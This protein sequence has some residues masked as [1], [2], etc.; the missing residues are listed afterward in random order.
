[1]PRETLPPGLLPNPISSSAPKPQRVSAIL[2]TLI[3]GLPL[4]FLLNIALDSAVSTGGFQRP[5]HSP[6]VIQIDIQNFS[7]VIPQGKP[8]KALGLDAGPANSQS[9][10][11]GTATTFSYEET[12]ALSIPALHQD[13]GQIG[14]AAVPHPFTAQGGYGDGSGKG[15]GIGTGKG[16][17]SKHGTKY[18]INQFPGIDVMELEDFFVFNQKAP[19]YPKQAMLDRIEGNV[20]AR[21]TF[22]EHG[23]PFSIDFMNGNPVFHQCIKDTVPNWRFEPLRQEG[24]NVKATVEITFIFS[25]WIERRAQH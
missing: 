22:D 17:G 18:V 6:K 4:A 1:M 8:N 16:G 23:I 3:F 25:L 12:K 15:I 13:S 7:Q 20:V 19:D 24:K 21:I 14:V 2:L 11:E 9:V 10:M 5:K